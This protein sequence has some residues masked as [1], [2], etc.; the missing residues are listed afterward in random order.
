MGEP[1]ILTAG[2][3]E[4]AGQPFIKFAPAAQQEVGW[5]ADFLNAIRTTPAEIVIIGQARSGKS[6]LAQ[7]LKSSG[8]KEAV[9]E[10]R[11]ASEASFTQAVHLIVLRQNDVSGAHQLSEMLGKRATMDELLALPRGQAL[12][13]VA[14]KPNVALVD[15]ARPDA[16]PLFCA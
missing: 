5:L 12:I 15:I 10:H 8:V 4:V 2:Y 3:R 1:Y 9:T 6:V 14:G 16:G 7:M 13:R 11:L